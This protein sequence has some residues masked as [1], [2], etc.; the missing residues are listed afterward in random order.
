MTITPTLNYGFLKVSA[1]TEI[2]IWA[3]PWNDSLDD[4][5]ATIKLRQD[6]A[7]A[8]STA[9]GAAQT[10]ANAA[11]PKAGGTMTGPIVLSAD[12]V[13]PLQPSTKQY[14][15]AALLLKS[16]KGVVDGLT[17]YTATGSFALTDLGAVVQL[18]SASAIVMTIP[19]QATVVWP[20]NARFDIVRTGAGDVSIAIPVGGTIL[21]VAT[22]K[23]LKDQYSGGT[24]VR[25]SLDNWLL[26]GDLKV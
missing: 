5:D 4:I 22:K 20:V 3:T 2:D 23:R 10:T 19:L 7:A 12:P 17:L 9:A 11:L 18:N 24:L 16:D 6:E 8:A 14:T 25:L 21:S 13:A 15:D 1:G 26:I